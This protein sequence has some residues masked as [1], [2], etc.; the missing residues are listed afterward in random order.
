[1]PVTSVAGSVLNSI[2][3]TPVVRLRRIVGVVASHRLEVDAGRGVVRC[4]LRPQ[5]AS[6]ALP[7]T[8]LWRVHPLPGE[9]AWPDQNGEPDLFVGR[10][11][12]AQQSLPIPTGA[13]VDRHAG[14]VYVTINSL[15]PGAAQVIKLP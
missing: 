1:M 5:T 9:T 12:H 7:Q 3:G 15:V 2:G 10:V 4:L 13:A 14:E 6:R 8:D 11:V